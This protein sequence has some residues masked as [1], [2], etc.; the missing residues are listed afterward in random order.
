MGERTDALHIFT[1][2]SGNYNKLSNGEPIGESIV[3]D[4]R[5][6]FIT[7]FKNDYRYNYYNWEKLE[8]TGTPND[9]CYYN[10]DSDNDFKIKS[11]I[12][13][14]ISVEGKKDDRI[15]IPED[16][17]NS[18]SNINYIRDDSYTKGK[19]P[20]LKVGEKFYIPDITINDNYSEKAL[21]IVDLL[22][23]NELFKSNNYKNIDDIFLLD[24]YKE[25][26]YKIDTLKNKIISD[27][28]DIK[29]SIKQDIF[30]KLKI[31][32]KIDK[33]SGAKKDITDKLI[34]TIIE[35]R[36][37]KMANLN[38][39]KN[40]NEKVGGGKS[41]SIKDLD[42]RLLNI[43][44][45]I[46]NIKRIEIQLNEY[47]VN[48]LSTIK[49]L[50][51]KDSNSEDYTF[52]L[53]NGKD[54]DNSP[55]S[56]EDKNCNNTENITKIIKDN[57]I[58]KYKKYLALI[59]FFSN[60]RNIDTSNQRGGAE[61]VYQQILN[62]MNLQRP[63]QLQPQ[64]LQQ[65]QPQQLQ[66]LQQLQQQQQLQQLQQQQL[67]PQQ[68]QQEYT[69]KNEQKKNIPSA[70]KAD[71]KDISFQTNKI[72]A[73]LKDTYIELAK[74]YK[75]IANNLDSIKIYADKLI[76]EIIK[77]E[78]E[79][80][81]S[82]F[83][84]LKN[85]IETDTLNIKTQE[86]KLKSNLEE[87]L[88]NAKEK[89]N[90]AAIQAAGKQKIINNYQIDTR[91][92]YRASES[93]NSLNTHREQIEKKRDELLAFLKKLDNKLNELKK[94]PYATEYI[95]HINTIK[96]TFKLEYV[97]EKAN[98]NNCKIIK[99]IEDYIAELTITYNK[100]QQQNKIN[101]SINNNS[102]PPDKA[103][104]I[105]NENKNISNEI[106][107]KLKGKRLKELEKLIDYNKDF[108]NIIELL[109]ETNYDENIIND[110]KNLKKKRVDNEG[111]E[112]LYE[113]LWDDYNRG[114]SINNKVSNRGSQYFTYL[115]EGEKLKNSIILNDLDPEIVLKVT[116]QDKAV[117]LL[118]IFIIRTICIV[119]IELLIEYNMLKSLQSSI[120]AYTLL[121]LTILLLFIIFINLD[122]YKLRIIFN[123]LN[124]HANTS[125]VIIHIVLFSIF[126][127]LVIIIIQTDN[128]INNVIDIFDYT[129]IYNYLFDFS[130]GKAFNSEFENNISPDEKIK[131][132]YRLD[133]VSMI[134]F[135]F[136]GILVILI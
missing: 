100:F 110:G 95:D 37:K 107:N 10:L 85:A 76:N 123:Y 52:K 7:L 114:I 131:L 129:Y 117:F 115:N 116:I 50:I 25:F 60:D 11:K 119:I 124:M 122:S 34:E 9:R 22:K 64:Q 38:L 3:S 70:E 30:D 66:Q 65:L 68:L 133:I 41:V 118:L 27:D 136:T 81:S 86:A 111:E 46:N 84:S 75:T 78:D 79:D 5:Q 105:D 8:V 72:L 33:K 90:D 128:F 93:I 59:Y 80:S 55:G 13:R 19:Y 20:Y 108:V 71:S 54:K 49:Y 58:K 98:S 53:S 26:K 4:L 69:G 103:I 88:K 94:I 57:S 99:E 87:E 73:D 83:K 48:I 45:S 132:L 40:Y 126:A 6:Y 77:S 74:I 120:V 96:N 67:Q 97:K 127:F 31:I 1:N 82:D 29:E 112:L 106:S 130:F 89:V 28:D 104:E 15:E 18:V 39:I 42:G 91:E 17:L 47:D 43:Y 44:Q 102:L 62:P 61:P 125:N 92:K 63:Q 135:I 113:T 51:N 134:I 12:K 23:L 32:Y 16:L 56:I 2:N 35:E 21:L 121:Y 36:A 24:F 109:K 14:Y 101:N